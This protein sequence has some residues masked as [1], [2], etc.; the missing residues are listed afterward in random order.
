MM[1]LK[2]VAGAIDTRHTPVFGIGVERCR[3]TVK[4]NPMPG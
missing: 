3:K 1:E 2:K 4:H